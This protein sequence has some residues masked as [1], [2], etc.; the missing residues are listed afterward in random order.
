VGDAEQ[1]EQALPDA[2]T[3]SPSTR[4]E[5]EV[6][7]WT[8]ART[9]PC[10][11]AGGCCRNSATRCRR[12]GEPAPRSCSCAPPSSADRHRLPRLAGGRRAV[13][14][15]AGLTPVSLEDVS[16][17]LA[18]HGP[19]A[20]AAVAGDAAIAG[21]TP[22]ATCGP[23]RCR[24]RAARG[25]TLR[26][27]PAAGQP[28]ATPATPSGRAL[29]A[30]P[31]ATRSSVTG[32]DRAHLRLLRQHAAVPQGRREGGHRD[33]RR[34]R[35]RHERPRAPVHVDTLRTV[36][37]Q[38]PHESLNLNARRGLLVAV[39]GYRPRTPASSTSTTSRRTAA[40][41]C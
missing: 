25:G 3:T 29:R 18:T 21:A 1:H 4:T 23:G 5:A 13:A 12:H 24:R 11:S 28:R 22:R 10:V 34:L 37:M 19:A 17:Y 9:T 27:T 39:M 7:R 16:G 38:S 33:D 2:P 20:A 15:N 31:G 30:G 41:R 40:T 14:A 36:A 32:P 26:T 6:T 8:T 35:P